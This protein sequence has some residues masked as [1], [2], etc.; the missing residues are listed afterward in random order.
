M[1]V[2]INGSDPQRRLLTPATYRARNNEFWPKS[3]RGRPLGTSG[4]NAHMNTML[5]RIQWRM[6]WRMP[7]LS[8]PWGAFVWCFRGCCEGRTSHA[9]QDTFAY[10]IRMP[11]NGMRKLRT[12]LRMPWGLLWPIL[13]PILW[14]MPMRM[15]MRML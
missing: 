2:A 15:H 7:W 8:M 14:R 10:A 5:C 12:P 3:L 4:E 6:P 11:F 9:I 13:W 1:I